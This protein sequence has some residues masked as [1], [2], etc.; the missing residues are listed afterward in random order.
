MEY[1]AAIL[2]DTAV[3]VTLLIIG[4]LVFLA[5]WCWAAARNVRVLDQELEMARLVG[6][7]TA[8]KNPGLVW[9]TGELYKGP[10]ERVGSNALFGAMQRAW[11]EETLK[12]TAKWAED[13]DPDF[14]RE[15]TEET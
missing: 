9:Y 5:L 6:L 15:L 10:D 2:T 8:L 1:L 11:P 7:M 3:V 12:I 13:T 14:Q 4:A